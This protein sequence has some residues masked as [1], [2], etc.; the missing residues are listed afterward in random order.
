MLTV[1]DL[2]ELENYIRSGQLEA[3]FKEGCEKDRFYLLELLEKLMD[4][5]E[6]AD[7]AATRL[8]F[9]GLPVPP[10]PAE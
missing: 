10:P 2:E 4:V 5:A 8:I 6:L 3:D 1:N 9:R 7:A